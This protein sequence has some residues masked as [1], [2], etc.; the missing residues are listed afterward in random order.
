SSTCSTTWLPVDANAVAVTSAPNVS[1][2]TSSRIALSV[3]Q[4][5]VQKRQKGVA[6]FRVAPCIR[7][8]C[9]KITELVATVIGGPGHAVSGDRM[10]L[11][12]FGNRIGKLDFITGTRR[13]V[14]EQGKDVCRQN[15]APYHR[16]VRGCLRRRRRFNDAGH[17]CTVTRCRY[18]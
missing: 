16:Q 12:E 2:Y 8:R 18:V 14:G 17:R 6:H 5:I 4:V 15:I 9:F 11:H 1:P 3:R 7:Q 13:G 10:L